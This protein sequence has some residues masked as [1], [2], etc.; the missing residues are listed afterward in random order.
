MLL[1]VVLVLAAC[2][3]DSN[4]GNG[5]STEVSQGETVY[6]QKCS[7]CHGGD[8]QGISGPALTDAG[9]NFSVEELEDIIKNGTGGMPPINLKDDERTAVAEWLAEKK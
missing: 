4:D 9:A 3:G 1:G 5:N 7:G 6:K 8:L 2:G